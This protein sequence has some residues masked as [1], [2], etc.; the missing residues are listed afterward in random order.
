[1]K[2]DIEILKKDISDLGLNREQMQ[3][4]FKNI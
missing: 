2:I 3:Y 4:I 1:M